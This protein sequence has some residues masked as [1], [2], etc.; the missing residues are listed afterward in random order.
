MISHDYRRRT[1]SLNHLQALADADGRIRWVISLEDPGV[2]NWLDG[3]G[4]AA[5]AILL[6][7][8]QLPGNAQ[9]ADAV[10]TELVKFEDLRAHLPAGTRF[11]SQ[12]E[13]AAQRD[14]RLEGYLTRVR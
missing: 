2:H 5:G 4:A 9:F 12:A 6:R 14:G 11:V 3:S 7:W 13:R 8:Q 10:S 1:S